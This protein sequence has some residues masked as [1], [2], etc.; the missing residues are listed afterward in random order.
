MYL[1]CNFYRERKLDLEEKLRSIKKKIM[2]GGE[3][4]VDKSKD[5]EEFLQRAMKE[6][7]VRKEEQKK[8]RIS[9]TSVLVGLVSKRKELRIK[10]EYYSIKSLLS[11]VHR[12]SELLRKRRLWTCSVI[13]QP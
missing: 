7:Q 4:L 6:L 9:L 12:R 2:I 10:A 13:I 5:Q 1:A 11:T 3:N 8:L